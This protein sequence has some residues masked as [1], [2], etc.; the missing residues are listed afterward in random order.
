M[1]IWLGIL[2][3]C[4][5]A[6]TR[7]YTSRLPPA[8]RN[9]RRAEIDSDL[10]EWLAD[11]ASEPPGTGAVRLLLR[12]LLGMPDD[13]AWR[14]EL[15]VLDPVSH[16]SLTLIGQ[17]LGAAFVL[18]AMGVI[19]VDAIRK[20]SGVTVAR[21]HPPAFEAA[22]VKVNRSGRPSGDDKVLPGG[23]YIAENL[24]LIYLIR[25]AY[26]R[27]PRSR[28]LAPAD[29][30]GGPAWLRSDRFDIN[31]TAGRDVSLTELRL[32]L[33]TLFEDRFTLKVHF[34]TREM[35]VYRMVLAQPRKLGSQL[36]RTS[37]DCASAPLDPLRGITP[38]EGYPCGYFGPSPN[39]KLGS[40]RAY[41]AFRG[42]TM[43]D[44][45]LRLHEFL[46][47]PV[48]DGTG[49][50]GYFDG[51]FE[52]TTEIVM[53]PPPPGQPNPYDGRV[54]PSIFSVMPQQLGLKLN[55]QRGPGEILVIDRVEHPTED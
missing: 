34:E 48:I 53:P 22:S 33:Q 32:M 25:F 17:T 2:I 38:G 41:Q 50:S 3:A 49:L 13:V 27:S 54:L 26:E 51:D 10:W 55:S 43:E 11:Q 12:L 47:R 7:L 8:V 36:T 42:M 44:F 18:C 30:A 28:G 5:R 6:W 52:F 31:A 35:P 46:G 45:G 19:H 20:Q 23:R 24:P 4:V 21:T 39:F 40:D 14:V 37:A 29:A 1:N 9:R 16:R 15:G